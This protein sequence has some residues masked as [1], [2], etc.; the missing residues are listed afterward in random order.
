M[1]HSGCDGKLTVNYSEPAGTGSTCTLSS[2]FPQPMNFIGVMHSGC[3]PP[4]RP[5]SGGSTTAPAAG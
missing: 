2:L 5:G 3:R 1:K 4:P